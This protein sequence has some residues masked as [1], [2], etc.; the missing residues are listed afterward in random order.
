ME[1]T[2][3]RYKVDEDA[4]AGC[5]AI[6]R[7]TQWGDQKRVFVISGHI[8]SERLELRLKLLYGD[9]NYYRLSSE[10]R[11]KLIDLE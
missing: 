1:S 7:Q 4:R 11:P 3:R 2:F 10:R 5:V 8:T 6:G 9:M